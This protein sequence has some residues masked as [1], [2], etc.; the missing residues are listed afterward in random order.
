[1]QYETGPEQEPK[2]LGQGEQEV[3]AWVSK[4][5]EIKNNF[6]TVKYYSKSFSQEALIICFLQK[7]K[8]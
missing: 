1:M 4:A 5:A 6:K 2:N 8:S 3:F 7:R